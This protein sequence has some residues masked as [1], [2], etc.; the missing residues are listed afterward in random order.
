MMNSGSSGGLVRNIISVFRRKNEST[1][2]E[3]GRK[4]ANFDGDADGRVFDADGDDVHHRAGADG[5]GGGREE[6]EDAQMGLSLIH[7]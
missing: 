5:E 1:V 3:K 6:G 2:A 4:N 7:I